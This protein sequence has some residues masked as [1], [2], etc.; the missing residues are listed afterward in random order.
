LLTD[1]AGDGYKV[2]GETIVLTAGDQTIAGTKTF[3]TAPAITGSGFVFTTGDQTIAGTKTFSSAPVFPTTLFDWGTYTPTLFNTTNVSASTAYQCQ[4]FR[5]GPN[6]TVSGFIEI[7]IT[8]ASTTTVLGMSIPVASNFTSNSQ[9]C[10]GAFG[11]GGESWRIISDSTN[12]RISFSNNTQT[13]TA[14]V[15]YTFVFT[16][17]VI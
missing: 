13:N 7:D 3:S 12:D 9:G 5:V 6:V 17:R 1:R 14:N 4:W 11:S 8:T 2:A 15:F 16:Y 10:G